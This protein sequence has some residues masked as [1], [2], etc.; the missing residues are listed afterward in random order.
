M[1]VLAYIIA[2]RA[3]KNGKLLDLAIAF[4]EQKAIGLLIEQ[5]CKQ[6]LIKKGFRNIVEQNERFLMLPANIEELTK[7]IEEQLVSLFDTIE[8]EDCVS[9][10]LFSKDGELIAELP[11]GEI[12]EPIPFHTFFGTEKLAYGDKFYVQKS[13]INNHEESDPTIE[14]E[15]EVLI[16]NGKMY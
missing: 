4:Q 2:N 6:D 11:V 14:P 10:A 9:I 7:N 3:W 8:T 15:Y 12:K 13:V 1:N 16:F 5:S